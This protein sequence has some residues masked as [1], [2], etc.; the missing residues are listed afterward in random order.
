MS[1]V[2]APMSTERKEGSAHRSGSGRVLDAATGILAA[3]AF[4]VGVFGCSP[5]RDPSR[6]GPND[7]DRAAA[8][9]T[10]SKAAKVPRQRCSTAEGPHGNFRIAVTFDPSGQVAES[11]VEGAF[12]SVP[13]QADV[14]SCVER[15]FRDAAVPAYHDTPVT[16]HKTFVLD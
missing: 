4:V 9:S 16:V 7:F 8:L 1:T 11:H 12:E 15:V 2:R 6:F 14:R 10:L 3:T 13:S 5:V